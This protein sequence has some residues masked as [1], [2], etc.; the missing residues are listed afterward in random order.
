MAVGKEVY[1]PLRR[2]AS[3]N[4]KLIDENVCTMYTYHYYESKREQLL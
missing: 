1:E 2:V 4:G 3:S